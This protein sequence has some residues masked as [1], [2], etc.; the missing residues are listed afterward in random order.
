MYTANTPDATVI[1]ATTRVKMDAAI[2]DGDDKVSF[3][4]RN[5]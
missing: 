1:N 3:L 4:Q 5:L 2:A